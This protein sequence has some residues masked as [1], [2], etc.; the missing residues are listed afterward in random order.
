MPSIKLIKNN[1]VIRAMLIGAFTGFLGVILFILILQMPQKKENDEVITTSQTQTPNEQESI[2]QAF[3]ALQHGVFSNFDSA[4]QF[5]ASYPTLNKAA[6]VEVN[7]QYFVW[8]RI[9]IE[10]VESALATVPSAF[11]KKITLESS[12]PKN[13]ELQLPKTLKDTKWLT[14][15]AADE[16]EG[17]VVPE[18]WL[19]RVLE[20][21]KLSTNPSVIRLHMFLN[22]YERLD[23]LKI[24]F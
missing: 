20:I 9:D 5:L 10:K 2:A 18:D 14:V 16:L 6:I 15:Q 21:Q 22:Y 17:G 23:C 8:S 3:L 19:T 4:A 12:C 7:D 24:T 1:A 11:Y 13:A